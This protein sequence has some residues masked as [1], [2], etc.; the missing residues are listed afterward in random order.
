MASARSGATGAR[1]SPSV[2]RPGDLPLESE[3]KNPIAFRRII[4]RDRHGA[5]ISM[6]WIRLKGRHRRIVCHASDRVYYILAGTAEFRLGDAQ[7]QKT[8]AGDSVFIPRG[9]PYDF[10]GEIEYLVMNGPA[11]LPGSDVYLD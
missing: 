3:T 5:G 8:S 9:T 10:T 6:T 11:F 1:P 7:P 2:I 4:R